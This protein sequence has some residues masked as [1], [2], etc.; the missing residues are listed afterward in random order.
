MVRKF[1]ESAHIESTSI[2]APMASNPLTCHVLDTSTGSQRLEYQL[3]DSDGRVGNLISSEEFTPSRYKLTFD[4]LAYYEG[5]GEKTF[6]PYIDVVFEIERPEEHYHVPILLSA[7]G[8]PTYRALKFYV[9]LNHLRINRLEWRA[10][11]LAI[12]EIK[13]YDLIIYNLIHNQKFVTSFQNTTS[14]K[15]VKLSNEIRKEKK[16]ATVELQIPVVSEVINQMGEP[17]YTGEERAFCKLV[18]QV[19]EEE[20]KDSVLKSTFT[21]TTGSTVGVR[22]EGKCLTRLLNECE[23]SVRIDLWAE[24]EGRDG[25]KVATFNYTNDI[26][27]IHQC[28]LLMKMK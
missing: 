17:E 7:Y 5:R 25:D 12:S 23:K 10:T 16:K 24:M 3:T 21:T 22:F 28:Q 1:F 6:Y 11:K 27:K 18:Q 4:T 19:L 2:Q 14:E 13:Q 15:D 20:E 26:T 8:Y 9:S